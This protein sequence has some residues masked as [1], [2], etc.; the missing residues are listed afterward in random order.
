MYANNNNNTH[1]TTTITAN[2]NSNN[3]SKSNSRPHR[4]WILR[5]LEG[6]PP[7]NDAECEN[8]SLIICY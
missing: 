6:A 1:D 5:I 8:C 3:N 2:N 7:E 4:C